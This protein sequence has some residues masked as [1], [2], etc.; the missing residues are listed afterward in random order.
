MDH[1][2]DLL[3]QLSQIAR[4]ERAQLAALARREGVSAEAAVDC[5][6]EALCTLL[7]QAQNELPSVGRSTPGTNAARGR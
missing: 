1:T 3:E 2:P 6:Q 5:I 4:R 7:T